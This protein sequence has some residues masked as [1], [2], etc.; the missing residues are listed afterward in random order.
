MSTKHSPLSQLKAQANTIAATI[1]AAER[2]D[3]IDV[4]FAQKIAEARLKET[5][6]V[7]IVMDDKVLTIEIPWATIQD[8]TE[9]SLATWIL[10]EM[11][12]GRK[13]GEA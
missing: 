3:K 12:E 2:G 9:A 4:R 11:Q 13:K 1:K 7:G 8:T 6:K 5:F 10:N